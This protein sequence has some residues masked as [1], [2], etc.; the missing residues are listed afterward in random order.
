[1][2]TT[3]QNRVTFAKEQLSLFVRHQSP[4]G[5][6]QNARIPIRIE[7]K[8]YI[9]KS[10]ESTGDRNQVFRLRYQVFHREQLGKKFPVGLDID[11]F[12]LH[13]DHLMI[14]DQESGACIGTYRMLCSSFTDDF[15]SRQEFDLEPVLRLPG[16]KVELG[17]ACVDHRFRK[18]S[19]LN[20]LWRG[21]GAYIQKAGASYLFG[22]AS[23]HTTNSKELSAIMSF[24][25]EQKHL[26]RDFWLQT[27]PGYLPAR[28]VSA[29]R[30]SSTHS[31]DAK[32]IP[33]LPS[34]LISYLTAGA[35]VCGGPAIDRSMDCSDFFTLL[36]LKNTN[37]QFAKR[38]DLCSA[39]S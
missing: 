24:L 22:C 12:D 34:L 9:I 26:C 4:L 39:P 18:G 2:M 38:Y 15:Y 14:I 32:S 28:A 5:K 21:V 35:K 7:T 27:Q 25:S 10:A 13:C 1:M 31:N 37:P 16:I 6:T 36:D 29:S 19:V 33:S 17:R 8:R 23:L 3:F 30:N 11:R 20:L